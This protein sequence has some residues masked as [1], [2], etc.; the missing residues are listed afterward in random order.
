MWQKIK[1]TSIVLLNIFEKSKCFEEK[2]YL[3]KI[4]LT[5]VRKLHLK[6]FEKNVFKNCESKLKSPED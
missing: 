6:R 2:Y 1:V 3:A 4:R 5:K